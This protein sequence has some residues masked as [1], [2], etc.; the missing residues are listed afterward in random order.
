MMCFSFLIWLI[1]LFVFLFSCHGCLIGRVDL[2]VSYV[3]CRFGCSCYLFV[4]CCFD[5]F[6][7]ICRV[8]CCLFDE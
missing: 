2:S 7:C 6:V 8:S 3:S 1:S 4:C 5:L